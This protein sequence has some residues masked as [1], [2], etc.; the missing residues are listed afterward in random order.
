MDGSNTVT[1]DGTV[2]HVTEVK[3]RT[4]ESI[5]NNLCL[6]SKFELGVSCTKLHQYAL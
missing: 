2:W 4:E 1:F 3:N 5:Q 6:W